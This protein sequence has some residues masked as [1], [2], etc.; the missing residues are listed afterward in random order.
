MNQ[1]YGS[2]LASCR[3]SNYFPLCHETHNNREETD[4]Q[5][6]IASDM[7]RETGQQSTDR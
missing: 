2:E 4:R 6:P 7:D 3:Q 5:T 1:L